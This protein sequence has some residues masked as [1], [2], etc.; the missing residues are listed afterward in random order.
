MTWGELERRLLATPHRNWMLSLTQ[1][2]VL[3]R[4]KRRVPSHNTTHGDIGT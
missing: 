4:E 2:D 1:Y 3:L